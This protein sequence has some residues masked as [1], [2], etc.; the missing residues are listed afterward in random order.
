MNRVLIVG[1]GSFVGESV[2]NWLINKCSGKYSV[3]TVDAIADAWKVADFTQYDVVYQVAGVA[4]VA[5][6][7]PEMKD[8]FFKV[9]AEMSAQIAACAKSAG[10]K[11]YIFMSTKGVYPAFV[12]LIDENT[13][14]NPQKL[15]GQ[16]K[17]AGEEKLNLLRDD[18]FKVAILRCPAVYGGKAPGSFHKLLTKIS[19]MK[20]FPA[21]RNKRS[22]I[23]IDNLCEFVNLVIERELDG[24]LV[25]QDA[26]YMSTSDIVRIA[27]K[28]K[29]KNIYFLR[30]PSLLMPLLVKLSYKFRKPFGNTVFKQNFSV[31]DREYY[32]VSQEDAIK[33]SVEY[34]EQNKGE[35]KS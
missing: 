14:T 6:E 7:T 1:A 33:R 20:V 2:E 18:R 5:K 28:S 25:P 24:I 4:H 27:A 17:L 15:Y 34:Q 26:E 16:S 10:V 9:N 11:Q 23:Y 8:L 29:G 19:T 12:P 22:M 31:N 35:F 3:D 13:P 32:V 30:L 21:Y